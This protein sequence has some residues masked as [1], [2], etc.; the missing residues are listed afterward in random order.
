MSC[1]NETIEELFAREARLKSEAMIEFLKSPNVDAANEFMTRF[2][3]SERR[4]HIVLMLLPLLYP[5][6][7]ALD[8]WRWIAARWSGFDLIPQSQFEK[9]FRFYKLGWSPD[10][11]SAASRTV[12]DALPSVFT[13]YRGQDHSAR[14]G[15]SWTLERS[16]AA[17]FARGHRGLHNPSP[18]ILCRTFRKSSVAMVLMGRNEHEV[19]LFRRP[20]FQNADRTPL[21]DQTASPNS[22]VL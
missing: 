11:M 18:V 3:E 8:A 10:C 9:V 19:V 16:V 2:V 12:Y 15:L 20:H 22:A 21:S 13:A 4:P 7:A 17:D 6:P 1:K 14:A 5:N